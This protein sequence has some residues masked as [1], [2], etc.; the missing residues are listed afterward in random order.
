MNKKKIYV[1]LAM[2]LFFVTSGALPA[3]AAV[4]ETS[5]FSTY[6]LNYSYRFKNYPP[7]KYRGLTL[8]Y[9]HKAKDGYV[10]FYI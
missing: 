4:E 3:Q 6:A 8:Q 5:E 7:K 10:G 1:V 2:V 9:V